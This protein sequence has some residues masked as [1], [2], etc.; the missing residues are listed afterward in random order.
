VGFGLK[1]QLTTLILVP[2]D[3]QSLKKLHLLH[4]DK[5]MQTRV[6]FEL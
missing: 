1:A 2:S 6:G 4:Q 5:H 3:I